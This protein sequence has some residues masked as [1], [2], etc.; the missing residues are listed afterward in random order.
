MPAD[1]SLVRAIREPASRAAY[2]ALPA[3]D[4]TYAT[5]CR[6]L[7]EPRGMTRIQG[8]TAATR[9]RRGR[10]AR[11]LSGADSKACRSVSMRQA[12]SIEC[13]SHALVSSRQSERL[14]GMRVRGRTAAALEIGI[15]APLARHFSSHAKRA[16]PDHGLGSGVIAAALF[17]RQSAPPRR[18]MRWRGSS[19]W[20][21]GRPARVTA[22][23]W[24]STKVWR[25]QACLQRSTTSRVASARDKTRMPLTTKA[26]GPISQ[27]EDFVGMLRL[28]RNPGD[29][30]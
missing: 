14:P 22:L 30:G 12:G 28:I 7:R 10:P 11:W 3:R 9:P 8:T 17:R 1:H 20:R 26:L 18:C 2:R 24:P 21:H 15:R 25:E 19:R 23:L 13:R 16:H 6:D 5:A 29:S 27:G 4:W